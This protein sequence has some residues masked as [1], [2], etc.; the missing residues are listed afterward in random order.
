MFYQQVNLQVDH[1]QKL[2]EVIGSYLNKKF[3][4]ATSSGTDALMVS[5]LSIGIQP[6]MK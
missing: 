4:I 3:V 2:E 5:L 1:F 6:E